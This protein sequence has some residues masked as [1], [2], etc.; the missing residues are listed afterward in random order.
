M[1]HHDRIRMQQLWEKVCDSNLSSNDRGA[2]LEILTEWILASQG[3]FVPKR[4]LK[5]IDGQIDLMVRNLDTRDPLYQELGSFFLVECKNWVSP[6]GVQEVKNFIANLR[7]A[8]CRS[9]LLASMEGVTGQEKDENAE[10]TIRKFF[11]RDGIVVIVLDREDYESVLE[12]DQSLFELLLVKYEKIR[13][14]LR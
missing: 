1:L 6:V 9:G 10:Y 3:P 4:N 5:S 14:D 2:A 8:A 7:A 13:F 12:R 11:H